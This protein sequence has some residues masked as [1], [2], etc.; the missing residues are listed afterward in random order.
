[1]KSSD[2][3]VLAENVVQV[4][5]GVGYAYSVSPRSGIAPFEWLYVVAKLNVGIGAVVTFAVQISADEV[6]WYAVNIHPLAAGPKDVLAV[7]VTVAANV[8]AV[9][10]GLSIYAPFVRVVATVAPGP[11]P[12]TLSMYAVTVS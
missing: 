8:Q 12:I 11:A 10:L 2:R 6:D 3:Y 4:P 7:D 5:D 9:V 1:M